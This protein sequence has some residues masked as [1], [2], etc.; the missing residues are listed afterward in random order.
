MKDIKDKI[1]KFFTPDVLKTLTGFSKIE[2]DIPDFILK[3]GKYKFTNKEVVDELT[4]SSF[5]KGIYC[6]FI[7][8]YIKRK[9]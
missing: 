6:D 1:S 9:L 5:G 3:E 7:L 2:I 4:L 8:N